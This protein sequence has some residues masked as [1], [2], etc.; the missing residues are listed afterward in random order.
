M[1]IAYMSDEGIFS[2]VDIKPNTMIFVENNFIKF[3][4][5]NNDIQKIHVGQVRTIRCH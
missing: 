1:T 2:E 5:T 3:V 4:N